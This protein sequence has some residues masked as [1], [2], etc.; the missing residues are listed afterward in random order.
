MINRRF[1]GK[2]NERQAYL[3]RIDKR[4]ARALFELGATVYLVPS[5]FVPFGAWAQALP[6]KKDNF[7]YWSNNFDEISRNFQYYNCINAQTGY[8]PAY[9][10]NLLSNESFKPVKI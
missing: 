1:L 8:F 4:K 5:N 3:C 7:E 10:I 6:I 9:Y 2:I